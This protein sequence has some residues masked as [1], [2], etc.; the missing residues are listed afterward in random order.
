MNHKPHHK[1][2]A[3]ENAIVMNLTVYP[4]DAV[5]NTLH[6]FKSSDNKILAIAVYDCWLGAK[7]NGAVAKQEL[8]AGIYKKLFSKDV[9]GLFPKNTGSNATI[10]NVPIYLTAA[11]DN[12]L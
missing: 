9:A 8:C 10:T 12:I 4:E 7:M 1:L 3:K 11:F 6:K 5:E 2:N